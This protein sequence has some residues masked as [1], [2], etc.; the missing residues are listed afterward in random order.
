[1]LSRLTILFSVLICLVIDVFPQSESNIDGKIFYRKEKSFFVMAHSAGWGGGYRT[2]NFITGFKKSFFEFEMV[3]FKHPKQ[4]KTSNPLFANSKSY[5]LGKLNNFYIPRVGFGI[6]KVI[7]NKPYWGG[8]ELRFIYS[9][10]ASLGI[11]KPV[12]LYIITDNPPPD[13]VLNLEKYNPDIHD[14]N[15]IYGR[16]PFSKGFENLRIHPGLYAKFGMNFEYGAWDETTRSLEA[17]VILDAFLK[18]VPLMAYQVKDQ[19]F[20]SFY[21]SFHFGKRYN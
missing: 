8:V 6:Q 10:G 19:F 18:P 14:F 1:M 9:G 12:Y 17:G 20:I 5:F 16:G 13:Q 15:N 21:L 11:T 4:I 7:N 3:S 2:G